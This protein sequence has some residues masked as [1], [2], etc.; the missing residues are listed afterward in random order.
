MRRVRV[1]L[2]FLYE[3]IVGDDPVIAL[4]VVIAL[5]ITAAVASTG[6]A[7]WWIMPAAVATVL[8]SSVRR[9]SR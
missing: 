3:F 9:A 6:T 1:F 4:A 2:T 7:A 8:T 5:G